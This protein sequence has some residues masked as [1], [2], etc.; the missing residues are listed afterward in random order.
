MGRGLVATKD[1]CRVGERGAWL[2]RQMGLLPVGESG[3][4]LR[5]Y[6]GLLPGR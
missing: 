5:R 4:W 6:K 1:Y 2:R 3:A